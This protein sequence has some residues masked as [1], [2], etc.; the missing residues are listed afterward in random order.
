MSKNRVV[1]GKLNAFLTNSWQSPKDLE[2]PEG[3]KVVSNMTY[4]ESEMKGVGDWVKVGTAEIT[5]T[6]FDQ[7]KIVEEKVESVKAA[8]QKEEADHS[9]RMMHFTD[10][11]N[12]L[13]AITHVPEE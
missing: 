8:M 1:K 6:L 9:V 4:V 7:D 3:Q 10:K 11:L 13:L 2:H 12:Q 5:V